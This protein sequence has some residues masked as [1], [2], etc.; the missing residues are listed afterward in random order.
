MPKSTP[1]QFRLITHLSYPEGKSVNDGIQEQDKVVTY[2]KFDDAVSMIA[3]LGLF[4][5]MSKIDL[6]HCFRIFPINPADFHLLAF[7]FQGSVYVDRAMCMGLAQA[8]QD[9]EK[10]TSFL[11]WQVRKTFRPSSPQS[12][13]YAHY[14]DDALLG[15]KCGTSECADLL[16]TTLQ[17]C[18]QLGVPIAGHKTVQPTTRLTFLGL[19]L[20]TSPVMQVRVPPDK[21]EH[22]QKMLHSFLLKRKVLVK[23]LESLVGK[24]AFLCRA[25]WPGRAFLRRLYDLLSQGKKKS[26]HISLSLEVKRDLHMWLK[27]L[28]NYN[29]VSMIRMIDTGQWDEQMWS[30]SAGNIGWA[31]LY[32][33]SWIQGLWPESWKS[34]NISMALKEIVP[35]ALALVTFGPDMARKKILMW[36]DNQTVVNILTKRSARCP[37]IMDYVRLIVQTCMQYEI[38]FVIRYVPSKDNSVCDA[39]SRYQMSRFSQVAPVGVDVNPTVVDCHL[40]PR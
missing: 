9:C 39:L 33:K 4:A 30:D 10:F 8:P 38:D 37:R 31:A 28:E 21:R 5:L 34:I 12:V 18:N 25:I 13:A 11:E 36:N 3:K 19:E 15:G 27:F 26:H 17:V 29:G 2:T 20:Q 40:S 32:K 22:A 35:V 7:E 23:E 6:Q 14:L 1:G 24:L 16:S